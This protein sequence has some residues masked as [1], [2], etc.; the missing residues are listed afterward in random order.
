MIS[1][2]FNF[3]ITMNNSCLAFIPA[4][5]GSKRIP[6]KNIL[7]FNNKPLIHHSIKAA[8]NSKC[9]SEICVSTDSEEISVYAKELGCL[10]VHRPATLSTDT[11]TTAE[12]A[13]HTLMF[14]EKKGLKFDSIATLQPTNPLRINKLISNCLEAYYSESDIDSLI[15]VS[16]NNR[17]LGQIKNKL[18]RPN[19][20]KTGQRSQ[21]LTDEFFENGLLYI[22]RCDMV[23]GEADLFG[24][25]I[26]PF[27]VDH[28]SGYIDIDEPYEFE[29]AEFLHNKYKTEFNL[30]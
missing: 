15:T 11:S 13:Q 14:L 8:L 16:L 23:I 1:G 30:E 24:K 18:F 20:Y 9:F 28:W 6:K 7:Q 4:R 12:A 26:K 25:N 29:I 22:S 27:I 17:K 5:I 21:D 2:I 19:N 10:V 3:I